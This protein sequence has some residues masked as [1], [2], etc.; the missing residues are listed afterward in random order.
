M[1]QFN[2]DSGSIAV[3]ATILM[4]C[5]LILTL[6]IMQFSAAT[7]LK[8][9]LSDMTFQIGRLISNRHD[10]FSGNLSSTDINKISK[11]FH[12]EERNISIFVEELAYGEIDSSG[13]NY[14]IL[15]LYHDIDGRHCDIDEALSV[16][17]VINA[18]NK[19]HSVYRV[20]LCRHI[21]SFNT[22]PIPNTLYNWFEVKFSS[23]HYGIHH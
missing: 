9:E 8:L 6:L 15:K 14:N 21:E 10:V 7:S 17:P 12:L 2:T 1:N 18:F 19:F 13:Q 22:L 5:L 23:T 11:A 20:T 4:P 16:Q 3:E